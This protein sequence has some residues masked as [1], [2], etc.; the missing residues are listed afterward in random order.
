[1][2]PPPLH[3]GSGWSRES[4]VAIAGG[5]LLACVAGYVD[6]V[7]FRLAN[8]A[9]THVTGSAA[10]VS[11][12]A[13]TG[14][15]DDA[16]AVVSVI[17]AF[18]VGAGVSGYIIGAS[19]LRLGRRYGIAL[20]IEG[21][22]LG[23][24][25]LAFD[26]SIAASVL[27]AA[28]A[29]GLQNAMASTYAGLIVRTTHLTGIATDIGFLAGLWLRHRRIEAWRFVLL[30]W[31]FG[32]FLLGAGAGTIGADRWGAESLLPVAMGV[33]GMGGAYVLWRTLRRR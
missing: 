21:L 26:W 13:T 3:R 17:A 4:A 28:A 2:T 9:V 22:L 5:G 25:A 33:G 23:L 24:S 18:I 29:A 7:F 32:G 10:R 31:L 1:M 6:A 19:E 8:I 16:A 20:L 14:R 27:L 15:F 12:D 11:A 30:L